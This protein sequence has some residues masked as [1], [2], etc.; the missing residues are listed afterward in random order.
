MNEQRI[1]NIFNRFDRRSF[2]CRLSEDPI[3][4]I[5]SL[6]QTI[7]STPTYARRRRYPD[8]GVNCSGAEN[9]TGATAS[10][11]RRCNERA[12]GDI[13]TLGALLESRLAAGGDWRSSG[14]LGSNGCRRLGSIAACGLFWRDASP[15]KRVLAMECFC[16]SN[17]QMSSMTRACI[18]TA[19]WW[20]CR[21]HE[22]R[23]NFI[24]CKRDKRRWRVCVAWHTVLCRPVYYRNW[25]TVI[26]NCCFLS[27]TVATLRHTLPLCSRCCWRCC[28]IETVLAIS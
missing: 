8:V 26:P 11:S 27:G 6:L 5:R 1:N 3:S 13:R 17:R 10:R 12:P 18:S 14:R 28:W 24:T 22:A 20:Q 2:P 9:E 16:S 4:A 25:I 19:S 23:A 15:S 21:A 7:K